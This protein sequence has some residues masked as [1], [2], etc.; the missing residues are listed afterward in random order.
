[1]LLFLDEDFGSLHFLLTILYYFLSYAWVLSKSK[2]IAYW[3]SMHGFLVMQI[4]KTLSEKCAI[5][6]GFA[7]D[8]HPL[9]YIN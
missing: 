5:C 9:F 3:I 4:F 1:V 6:T 2:L 8:S 7:Q